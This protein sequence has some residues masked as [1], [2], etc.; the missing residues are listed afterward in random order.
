MTQLLVSVR[1]AVEAIAAIEG[2]ADIVDVKEPAHGSLGCAI[3]EIIGKV[4][5]AV[6]SQRDAALPLSLALGELA[7]W[8]DG[9]KTPLRDA[10]STAQPQFL[11]LGLSGAGSLQNSDPWIGEWQGVRDAISGPHVWVAVAYADHENADSPTAES[12]LQAAIETK[13]GIL[14][15]DTYAKNGTSLLDHLTLNQLFAIRQATARHG[16]KLALAGRVTLSSLSPL[17]SIQAD[18][19]AVRSAVCENGDRTSSISRELVSE[20]RVAVHSM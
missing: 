18:I 8:R 12:V 20:F 15:I 19:I 2:L 4:A 9:N 5:A 6:R 13:C 16:L 17:V 3:P 7:E 1:N 14:L 11:K 10:I